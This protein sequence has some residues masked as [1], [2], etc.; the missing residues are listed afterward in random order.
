MMAVS[1]DRVLSPSKTFGRTTIQRFV[2]L[3]EGKSVFV[4]AGAALLSALIY[5][6]VF[7]RPYNLLELY[8]R[9]LLDL[10]RISKTDPMARW[11]LLGGFIG[12]G[13]LYWIGWRAART[14]RGRVAWIIVLGGTL[15]AS[16]ILLFSYPYDAADVFDNIM[17]GRILGVYGANPFERIPSDFKH[18]PFY[19]YTAWRGTT[20]AYGPGWELMAGGVARLVGNS[21]VTNVL[22]FKVLC[23]AFLLASIGVVA[24]I[25]RR[26]AS[27]RALAGVVLLAWNPVI[28]YETFGHGHNDMAMV[29]WILVAVWMLVERRLTLTILALV[30]GALVKFIPLLM[31]PAAMLVALRGLSHFRARLRFVAVTL[32]AA[33]ALAVLVY[34]PFWRGLETLDIERRQALFSTSLPAVAKVLLET[35]M[36]A[37]RSAAFI[38]RAAAGLTALFALWQAVRAWRNGTWLGFTRAVFHILMFYLL[39]TCLWFQSWYAV[40]PLGIAALLPPGHAARLGALFGMA[41]LSKPLIFGPLWLWIRP[42][43][44]GLWR[45]TRLGPAV[46][47]V[48]WL[49]SLLAICHSRRIYRRIRHFSIRRR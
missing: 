5:W 46:L 25:L 41:V 30:M 33:V 21:I 47:A 9:P 16:L 28:L 2:S 12:Q 17:H 34:A 20:S 13:A 36:D 43:P 45:E 4:L 37:E 11:R 15:V 7:V 19:R 26:V 29:F 14:A 27:E 38:S 44:S 42:L 10:Y 23:G 40:W 8:R 31:L 22:A 24:T 6:R 32:T 48:P 49:Y 18:D 35:K 1:G 3:L 39:L